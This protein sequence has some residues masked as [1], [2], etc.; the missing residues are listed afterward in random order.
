MSDRNSL[1]EQPARRPSHIDV[2][3]PARTAIAPYNFVPLP[4]TVVEAETEAHDV[5][6][7]L[8]A[9]DRHSGRISCTI[10]TETPLYI[11]AGLTKD[12]LENGRDAKQKPEFFYLD[13]D[14]K[15]PVIPGSSL[16]G[17]LRALVEI[18]SYSK[19]SRVSDSPLVYRA[20]DTTSLGTKYRAQIMQEDARNRY[21]PRIQAGYLEDTGAGWQIRPAEQIGGTSFARIAH[22]K[23]PRGLTQWSDGAKNTFVI[24]AKPGSYIHQPVRGGFLHIRYA[25]IER[26]D[27]T[28]ASDLRKCAMLQSGKMFSKKSETVIFP[29]DESA[30]A[31][32]VR[33]ELIDAYRDQMSKEQANLLDFEHEQRQKIMCRSDCYAIINRCYT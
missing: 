22:A 25:K 3:S 28:E 14:T 9:P 11:R 10:T 2:V 18:V 24:H 15:K 23:I 27:S 20:V 1:S 33:A 17:L 26:A 21:T 29:K 5:R 8:L 4:S 16:R 30:Q 31:I 32:P 7:D 13:P 19:V 6:H 12:E